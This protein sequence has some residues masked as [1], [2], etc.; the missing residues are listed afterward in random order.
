MTAPLPAADDLIAQLEK[1]HL[2]L[3]DE[4]RVS[5][6]TI[7]AYTADVH[8]MITFL[9]SHH[10]Q[11]I[12]LRHLS[13]ANITDFRG[14]LS[15]QAASGR[16]NTSRARTL[17][18]IKNFLSWCDRMG[19]LHNAAARLIQSP[20]RPHKLPKNL[21]VDESFKL[22]WADTGGH[23]WTDTRNRAIFTLLYGCGLRIDEALSL[24]IA[25]VPNGD[26]PLRVIGKGQKERIVPVL[27]AVA[28]MIDRYRAVCPF[29]EKPN[30]PLF[31][32]VKGGR[33]NQNMVQKSLRNL[34]G[35]LGLP[36]STTPHALRH[37]FATHLLE[38][39]ANLRE[40][41]ELLGHASLSTTQIYAD[42][43]AEELIRVYKKSHPRA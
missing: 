21:S 37:S 7:R 40:I 36:A 32:G 24:N 8:A 31:L 35:Q 6:H 4:K 1:W 11:A 23:D 29:A 9:S 15:R 22:L 5:R 28:Q 43:N 34:R 20:K 14:F 17:S 19:V 26:S 41:Q 12:S 18:G 38:N 25:D 30:R 33:L 13:D 2:Y 16:G 39:G 3:R 42:I 10:G 27:P